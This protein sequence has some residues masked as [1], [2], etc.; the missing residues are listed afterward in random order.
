MPFSSLVAFSFIYLFLLTSAYVLV[1]SIAENL[2]ELRDALKQIVSW[3]ITAPLDRT[4]SGSSA[5]R[6]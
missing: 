6:G 4:E 5:N 3:L 1:L 2:D